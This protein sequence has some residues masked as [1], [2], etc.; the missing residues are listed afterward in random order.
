MRSM[1]LPPPGRQRPMRR[2]VSQDPRMAP[3]TSMASAPYAEHDGMNRHGD[4][5]PARTDWYAWIRHISARAA[6]EGR[7]RTASIG[8]YPAWRA[9][10][11]RDTAVSESSSAERSSVNEQAAAAGCGRSSNAWAGSSCS[12]RRLNSRRRSR[13]RTTA[14]P[15]CFEIAKPTSGTAVS[16]PT[17]TVNGPRRTRVPPTANRL[18]ARRPRSDRVADPMV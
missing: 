9:A 13:F 15:T 17:T 1:P 5:R 14:P 3:C 6:S 10:R 12:A 18:N 8:I 4:G 7:G 16:S 2:A 11:T